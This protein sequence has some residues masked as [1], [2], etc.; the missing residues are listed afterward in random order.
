[1]AKYEVFLGGYS[2]LKNGYI[3]FYICHVTCKCKKKKFHCS[4]AKYSFIELPENPPHAR[5][6]TFKKKRLMEMRQFRG[7]F[8][9]SPQDP[10][11]V[12]GSTSRVWILVDLG[13]EMGGGLDIGVEMGR[14]RYM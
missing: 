3:T 6:K 9:C 2:T 11:V 13:V 8:R 4:F 12:I 5:V 7:A 1:M 14:F 10:G